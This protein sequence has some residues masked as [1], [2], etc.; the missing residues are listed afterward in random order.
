MKAEE[1]SFFRILGARAPFLR[2]TPRPGKS[3]EPTRT[4]HVHANREKMER[5]LAFGEH[6]NLS[7]LNLAN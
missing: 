6:V 5:N 7:G 4:T 1:G 3:V 2:R